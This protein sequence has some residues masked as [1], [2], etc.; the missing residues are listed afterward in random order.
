MKCR[1]AYYLRNMPNRLAILFEDGTAKV[2]SV[3]P[4]HPI[5]KSDLRPLAALENPAYRNAML[6]DELPEYLYRLYGLERV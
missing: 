6:R 4:L 5:E 2:A 3:N 1:K